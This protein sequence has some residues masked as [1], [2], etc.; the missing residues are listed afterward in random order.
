[1]HTIH[2]AIHPVGDTPQ[3]F[4]ELGLRGA[5][6][7]E[8]V[9]EVFEFVVELFLDLRELGGG[10]G[11]EVD[12]RVRYGGGLGG[13]GCIPGLEAMIPCGLVGSWG[14]GGVEVCAVVGS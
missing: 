13:M 14:V 8:G 5:Q 10:E 9:G 12:W 3:A 7:G 1:M 4:L 2:L 6:L 11:G